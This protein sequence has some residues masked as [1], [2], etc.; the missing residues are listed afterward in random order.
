Q[1][2]NRER[3]TAGNFD[4]KTKE[5]LHNAKK[6]IS[7]NRPDLIKFYY[8][9][10]YRLDD[11][12]NRIEMMRPLGYE[13]CFIDTFKPD[14]NSGDSARWEQFSNN[15]QDLHD[16][17]KEDSNNMAALATVQLKIGK[18]YRYLDLSVVG[19]S[20]EIVETAQLVLA[21]RMMYSDEYAGKRAL[22]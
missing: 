15:A 4:D 12:I 5:K 8:L 20:G 13:Y 21:G 3:M 9:K 10:K 17:V 16:A 18:E 7:Q 2:I 6:W 1:P 22:K 19:K 14:K 11:I